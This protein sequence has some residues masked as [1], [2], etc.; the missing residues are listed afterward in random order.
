MAFYFADIF[1][2]KASKLNNSSPL[3]KHIV[4]RIIKLRVDMP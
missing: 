2:I 4:F 1:G 3:Y